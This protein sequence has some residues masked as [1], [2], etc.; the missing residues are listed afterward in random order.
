VHNGGTRL[1]VLLLRNPHLLEGGERGQDGAADPHGVLALRRSHDL[2]LH[3]GGGQRLDLLLHAV[4]HTLEHGGTS[5]VSKNSNK[6]SN[7]T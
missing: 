4:G 2:N 5:C 6:Y 1:V 7:T 3:G